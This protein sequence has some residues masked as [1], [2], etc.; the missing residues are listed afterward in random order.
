MRDTSVGRMNW[1]HNTENTV[2]YYKTCN[3]T[4][5]QLEFTYHKTDSSHFWHCLHCSIHLFGPQGLDHINPGVLICA[6]LIMHITRIM[7]AIYNSIS[8]NLLFKKMF[9]STFSLLWSMLNFE[10]VVTCPL[11]TWRINFHKVE[12]P[13]HKDNAYQIQL[14]SGALIMFCFLILTIAA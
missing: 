5:L 10:L 14:H 6:C 8:A 12:S 13:C 2:I 3:T 1:R 11:N 4:C 9:S 7:H